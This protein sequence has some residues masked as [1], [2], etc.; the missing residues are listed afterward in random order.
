ML[1]FSLGQEIPEKEEKGEPLL[2][3][4]VRLVTAVQ[5][6]SKISITSIL[7]C[8]VSLLRQAQN[9]DGVHSVFGHPVLCPN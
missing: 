2:L 9:S 5:Y 1:E 8:F 7:F 4:P 6:Y 3:L